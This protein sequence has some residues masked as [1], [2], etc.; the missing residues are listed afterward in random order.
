MKCPK[1]G[2]ISF[3]Y[4]QACPKCDKDIS[5]EQAK[6][7]IPPFQPN[8]PSLLGAL[9]GEVNESQIGLR[10]DPSSILEKSLPEGIP[11]M[12]DASI[13][14]TGQFSFDDT[15]DTGID[16]EDEEELEELGEVGES[17]VEFEGLDESALA[18]EENLEGLDFESAGEE[19]IDLEETGADISLEPDEDFSL[20]LGD[21]SEEEEVETGQEP[22]LEAGEV[23]AEDLTLELSRASIEESVLSGGQDLEEP[24]LDEPGAGIDFGELETGTEGT[25]EAEE[26]ERR[27]PGKAERSIEEPAE[28]PEL[29]LGDLG[30]GSELAAEQPETA[31]EIDEI[32]LEETPE[33]SGFDESL[34][35]R[36]ESGTGIDLEALD[37]LEIEIDESEKTTD[38]QDEV[39]LNL[40]DL[41]VNETGELEIGAP[42]EPLE[43]EEAEEPEE[44][45]LEE[46]GRDQGREPLAGIEFEGPPIEA[47]AKTK[48][49]SGS[50]QGIEDTL[51]ELEEIS[52]SEEPI[53]ESGESEMTFEL[54]DLDLDLEFGDESEDDN[55]EK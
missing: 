53:D 47:P 46:Q 36:I 39:E 52:L 48:R 27:G 12:V 34:S 35:T 8:P 42:P 44:I 11:G 50:E 14:E 31:L 15:E 45:L 22:E 33:A 23:G 2:Y 37:E 18:E 29:E 3:D 21:F 1:C 20:D 6:L 5:S 16:F 30:L 43:M 49:P 10:V 13:D 32:F 28:E 40:E 9:T 4:N 38:E 54:E 25:G 7:N 17:E 55:K 41:K 24:A 51:I 26:P 19:E